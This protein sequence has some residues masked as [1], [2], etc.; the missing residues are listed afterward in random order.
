MNRKKKVLFF[1]PSSVGGAER[2]TLTIAKML[3][4]DE[5]EVKVV[6]VCNQIGNI[7]VFVPSWMQTVHVKIRNIWDF[8]TFRLY[9]TVRKECP[10]AV[11]SSLHY[12][13]SRVIFSSYLAGVKNIIVRNNIG[14]GKWG[15]SCKI[16]AKLT[17]WMASTIVLQSESMKKELE[18]A[19]PKC[20]YKMQVV[21]NPIDTETIKQ[22]TENSKSPY[23]KETVNYVY[24]GRIVPQKGLDVL[25]KSFSEVQKEIAEAH[26]FI[27]GDHTIDRKY[28]MRLLQLTKDEQIEDNVHFLGFQENPYLYVKYAN[29]F[30]LPSKIEGNPNVLHEAMYLK[31]PVVATRSVPVIDQCVTLER[32]YVVD[33]D[34]VKGLAK[35]MQKALKIK[36]IPLYQYGDNYR[37]VKLFK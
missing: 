3:P 8:T 7:K 34:D 9:H 1:T 32:G 13:N 18:G 29:C 25:L 31:V 12:L 24:S 23:S 35:A 22:R 15:L 16:L 19:L 2:V 30:V 6:Y 10:Y 27:V 33:V 26:L 37:F 28:Y 4:R 20:T 36:N 11:F 14:W 21:P 5:Y 17:Y